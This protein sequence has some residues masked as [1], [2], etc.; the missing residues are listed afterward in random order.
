M[1]VLKIGRQR[2]IHLLNRNL[3]QMSLVGGPVGNHEEGMCIFLTGSIFYE[4]GLLEMLKLAFTII[5]H[6]LVY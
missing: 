2:S 3:K 6:T 1:F 5:L 4:L